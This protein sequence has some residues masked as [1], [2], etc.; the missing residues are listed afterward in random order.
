VDLGVLVE[1]AARLLRH[2][3]E[4]G[5]NHRVSVEIAPG[6]STVDGDEAQLRQVIW[7]LAGNALR[8]M[9]DGGTL[10]LVLGPGAPGRLALSVVDT[11]V[12]IPAEDLDTMFQPFSSGFAAGTG[13]G[14]AIVHRFVSDSDGTITVG[15]APGKGTTMRVELPVHSSAGGGAG[16]PGPRPVVGRVA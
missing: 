12:G 3:P 14:L 10:R 4:C 9:P 8:A 13:L 11:G 7:N 15:S 6:P 5:A 16:I 1:E 2:S